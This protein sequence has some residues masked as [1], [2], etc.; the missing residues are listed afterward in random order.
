MGWLL[1]FFYLRICKLRFRTTTE[2]TPFNV[3]EIE[4]KRGDLFSLDTWQV[5]NDFQ[6]WWG[7]GRKKVTFGFSAWGLN[8]IQSWLISKKFEEKMK[9]M[10]KPSSLVTITG[11]IIRLG[12]EGRRHQ[13]R[14]G[15]ESSISWEMTPCSLLKVNRRFGRTALLAPCWFI[16][17]LTLQQWWL[18][19][20]LPSKRLLIFKEL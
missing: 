2:M 4:E 3:K 5:Q 16:A 6:T 20:Y 7:K 10:E 14:G 9:A 1:F 11:R 19:R 17:W 18:G 8:S 15:K 13:Y 12:I